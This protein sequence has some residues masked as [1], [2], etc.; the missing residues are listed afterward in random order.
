MT[1]EEIIEKLADRNI[2]IVAKAIGVHSNTLYNIV[3]N[4]SEPSYTVYQ[5]LIAYLKG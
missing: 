1:L 5:K 2:K 3:N 4:K